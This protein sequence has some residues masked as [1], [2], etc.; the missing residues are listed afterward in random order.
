MMVFIPLGLIGVFPSHWLLR[1]SFSAATMIDVIA[2]AG[3]AV[4]NSLLIVDFIT[5]RV[6]HGSSVEDAV[7]EVCVLIKFSFTG[8]ACF[9]A[10][11]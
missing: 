2:L 7:S 4:R 8:G 3:V 1:Q 11:V 6:E 5:V 10:L 9:K